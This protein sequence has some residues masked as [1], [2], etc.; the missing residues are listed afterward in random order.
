[1]KTLKDS[2]PRLHCLTVPTTFKTQRFDIGDD[3]SVIVYAYNKKGV[4]QFEHTPPTNRSSRL[5]MNG[6][7]FQWLMTR[8]FNTPTGFDRIG[9]KPKRPGWVVYRRDFKN[10]SV[11]LTSRGLTK[12]RRQYEFILITFTSAIMY[13]DGLWFKLSSRMTL[14]CDVLIACAAHFDTYIRQTEC[15]ACR[16]DK[17]VDIYQNPHSCAF[18][19]EDRKRSR[20]A[21]AM[22]MVGSELVCS[23]LASNR[24][25]SIQSAVRDTVGRDQESIIR[26]IMTYSISNQ[27]WG[28]L[29]NHRKTNNYLLT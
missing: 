24:L 16:S 27:A 10:Q 9:C 18:E 2:I 11:Q 12:L 8:G 21:E 28:M 4:I 25:P 20:A 14:V 15:N 7:E 13:N 29:E 1:M 22:R 26:R 17:R 6:K 23:V 5:C 3:V 19:N